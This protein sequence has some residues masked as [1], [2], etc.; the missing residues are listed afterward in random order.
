MSS[1]PAPLE[2]PERGTVLRTFSGTLPRPPGQVFE[3]LKTRLTPGSPEAGSFA[4]DPTTGLIVQQGGWWYRA[5]YRVTPDAAGSRVT[6]H[7]VNVAQPAH[8]LGPITGRDVLKGSGAAFDTLL[9]VL[10]AE[11]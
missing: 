9:A 2:R 1:V 10:A 11:A 8:W 3:S 5:E 7:I 4:S 6:L